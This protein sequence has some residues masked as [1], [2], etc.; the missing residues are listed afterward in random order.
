VY[1]KSSRRGGMC[2]GLICET[3][4]VHFSSLRLPINPR[5]GLFNDDILCWYTLQYED[6]A[7]LESMACLLLLPISSG[8]L[9]ALVETGCCGDTPGGF[10]RRRCPGGLGVALT[11]SGLGGRLRRKK[12][13]CSSCL[14]RPSAR[15]SC[16]CLLARRWLLVPCWG[17]SRR[18]SMWC[19][20]G[21]GG[22]M[23]QNSRYRMRTPRLT[24]SGSSPVSSAK[25]P[26]Q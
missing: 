13:T 15:S 12:A 23:M 17:C 11:P 24:R 8:R 5:R 18:S 1:V 20:G 10:S 7:F 9:A 21:L 19:E 25:E 4:F 26:L 3:S 2:F 16:R 6:V 22:T 14:L